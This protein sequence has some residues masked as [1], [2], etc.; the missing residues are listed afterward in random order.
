MKKRDLEK[1]GLHGEE[2]F[3]FAISLSARS[4]SLGLKKAAFKQRLSEVAQSPEQFIEDEVFGELARAQLEERAIP[5]GGGYELREIPYRHWGDEID[6]STFE[7]MDA[8]C[9]LPITRKAALM[10]DA[11]VGYGLP[12]GGVLATENAVIPYAVGV[13]IACRVML[14]VYDMPV[15]ELHRNRVR[16]EQIL[17]KHTSFGLGASWERYKNH[18]VMDRDWD[19]TPRTSTLKDMAWRQLGTSGSGNHFVEFGEIELHEEC[20]GVPAGEYVALVSHSG[21]R[22][23]GAKVALHYSA[24]AQDLHPRLPKKLKHL[25]WLDMDAEGAEYWAAME[26]MGAYASANHHVIHRDISKAL[27]RGVLMQMENHH[28]FAW[29]EEHDGKEL[30]VHRKGATPARQGELGYIPG[31]MVAPGFLVE[32][33]GNAS[34]LSSS[35]H[36][37]GRLLSRKRAKNTTTRNA[38]NAE[39]KEKGVSLLDAGLDEAPHAYKDIRRVMAAQDDLV[40]KLAT[41]QPRVVRMAPPDERPEG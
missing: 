2:V 12:I 13:D 4:K 30:I 6:K 8:A 31:T 33:K 35:A 34:S 40:R 18:N 10:P 9:S 39:L 36:G 37:A 17:S 41:F 1:L 14:T 24:M 22:G 20:Q 11:H 7:Q 28:N 32:G 27:S 38:L 21:S 3:S 15:R 26:L 19:I 5:E 16:L 25:A 23:P 29:K